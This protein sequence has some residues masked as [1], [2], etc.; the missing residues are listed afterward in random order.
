[1]SGFLKQTLKEKTDKQKTLPV[2]TVSN[3]VWTSGHGSSGHHT[4]NQSPQEHWKQELQRQRCGRFYALSCWGAADHGLLLAA[5]PGRH[6]WA[7]SLGTWDIL[8]YKPG[9]GRGPNQSMYI[10]WK[11]SPSYN[12]GQRKA[13]RTSSCR[14]SLFNF[15]SPGTP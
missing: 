15:S 8:V 7:D 9:K 5:R 3:S 6:K 11:E 13:K 4:Q 14:K 12:A 2:R 1:M 10:L